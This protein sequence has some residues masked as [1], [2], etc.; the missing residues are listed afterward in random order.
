[1][2]GAAVVEAFIG[3][4]AERNSLEAISNPLSAADRRA[5]SGL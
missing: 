4:K 1:M 3:V 2:I 5:A